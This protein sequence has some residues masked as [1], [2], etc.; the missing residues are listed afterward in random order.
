[1][2]ALVACERYRIR[3]G[4]WPESLQALVPEF[5]DKVPTDPYDGQ[6]LRYRRLP[7][8]AIVYSVG[9]NRKD[10]GGTRTDAKRNHDDIGRRLWDPNKRPKRHPFA[11]V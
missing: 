1:M 5:L 4:R 9:P 8:G 11:E 3:H 10:E 2:L 6:P 7:D